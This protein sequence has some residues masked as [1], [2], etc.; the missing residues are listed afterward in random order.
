[1]RE[2]GTL[3]VEDFGHENIDFALVFTVFSNTTRLK[4]NKK[5]IFKIVVT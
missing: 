4:H 5:D 1:M 3:G 2:R